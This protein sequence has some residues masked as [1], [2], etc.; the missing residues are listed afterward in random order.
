MKTFIIS[1]YL[2]TLLTTQLCAQEWKFIFPEYKDLPS[3]NV[4]TIVEDNNGMTWFGTN[5]G[6]ASFD[7]TTWKQYKKQEYNLP[8]SV[9]RQIVVDKDNNKWMATG[10]GLIKVSNNTVT[11]LNKT[12]SALP[13]DYIASIAVDDSNNVWV[14][15]FDELTA[16][17]NMVKLGKNK[18]ELIKTPK[19]RINKIRCD[20]NGNIWGACGEA[21]LMKYNKKEFV[22]FKHRLSDRYLNVKNFD[23]GKNNEIWVGGNFGIYKLVDTTFTPYLTISNGQKAISTFDWR[24]ISCDNE[25]NVWFNNEN[26]LIKY[27]GE[28]YYEIVSPQI[29]NGKLLSI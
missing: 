9:I 21:G 1:A 10:K 4:L 23:F 12:N 7:G 28:N 14:I 3:S 15:T 18:T 26:G 13:S 25:G 11:I 8:D 5:M 17:I 27:N 19:V 24:Y 6:F 22:F 29:S 20:K 16:A 2:C